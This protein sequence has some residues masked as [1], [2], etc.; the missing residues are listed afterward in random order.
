MDSNSSSPLQP[1]RVNNANNQIDDED[2]ANVDSPRQNL[3]ERDE[4]EEGSMSNVLTTD[5][6]EDVSMFSTLTTRS[7]R[8]R[9]AFKYKMKIS[10]KEMK[11]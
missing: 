8:I 2:P 5:R 11:N 6:E 3:A 7:T 1:R 9:R 4:S 10:V